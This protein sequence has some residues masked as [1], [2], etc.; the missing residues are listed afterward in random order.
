[1]LLLLRGLSIVIRLNL[2]SIQRNAALDRQLLRPACEYSEQAMARSKFEAPPPPAPPRCR[3]RHH[4]SVQG[5]LWSRHDD[6]AAHRGARW[7]PT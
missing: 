7:A 6:A 5:E 2:C 1:M 3:T 4:W